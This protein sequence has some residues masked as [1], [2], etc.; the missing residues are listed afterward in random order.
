MKIEKVLFM[1]PLIFVFFF[2]LYY[3]TPEL[4]PELDNIF[5]SITIFLFATLVGFFIARQATRYGQIISKVTD[6]DGN[7]SFLYRSII[8]FGTEAQNEFADILKKHYQSI[9]E[10]KDWDYYFSQK[11]TTLID[12]NNIIIKYAEN[13]NLNSAQ[14]SFTGKAFF[15]LG[16]MQKLR[17]NLIA[18]YKEKVPY[19]Q[20][21]LVILLTLMLII[22]V[23]SI[24]SYELLLASIIKAAFTTSIISV[25]MMLWKLNHLTFFEDMVGQSS[26]KDVLDIISGIK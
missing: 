4:L 1:V 22:T 21:I 19:F 12:A 18:L 3:L 25:V 9:I 10:N 26:G 2:L 11:T 6:F 7:M 23:S 15:A 17:K 5:I 20:W 16:D 24:P 13:E 14:N 8:V